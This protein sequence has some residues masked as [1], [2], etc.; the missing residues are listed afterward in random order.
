MIHHKRTPDRRKN[1]GINNL[2]NMTIVLLLFFFIAAALIKMD[3]FN[4]LL[5]GYSDCPTQYSFLNDVKELCVEANE[6][7]A[8][9]IRSRAPIHVVELE[10]Y[11]APKP[12]PAKFDENFENYADETIEVHYYK[13]RK[14]NSWFHYMEVRIK[15]P[16]Q[17]RVAFA[18]NKFA[19]SKTNR[20]LPTEISADVNAVCAVNGGFYNI[21]WGG[22]LI[23]RREMLRNKPF[24]IDVLLIDSRGNFH[25]VEDRNLKSSGLLEQ[26][27]IINSVSFGPELVRD[28][29]ELT[30]TK[31]NWQPSTEEPRT[32]ICQYDDELHYLICLAE[33]RNR[34]SVGVPLQTF[35]HEVAAKNVKTAYNLDGG[36]SGTLIIGNHLKNRVGWGTEK[37]QSDIIYFATAIDHN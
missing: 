4:M 10:E 13:E 37:P 34:A 2:L 22:I 26:Y 24:G 1:K 31:K 16:S 7:S 8:A 12:D 30:I 33:G 9:F 32:A 35:A 28:G 25:I 29:Q 20:K 3:V 19:Q 5:S 17:I 14:Y 11:V 6:S 18:Y 21:R 15:H 27:D 23:H 36:R